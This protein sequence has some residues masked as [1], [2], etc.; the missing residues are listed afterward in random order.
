ME[1]HL[2]L[3]LLGGLFLLSMLVSH[4]AHRLNIPRVTLLIVSGI[5]IGPSGLNLVNGLEQL[6]FPTISNITLLV[7]GY[8]LGTKMTKIYVKK[9]GIAVLI[10]ALVI[11]AMTFLVVLLGLI[12]LN[13]PPVLAAILAVIAVAT[14]PT[15]TL[16][17]I[18]QNTLKNN[19]QFKA[20]LRGV[21]ALD[22]ILGL[23]LFSIVIAILISL[24]A[25]NASILDI[26]KHFLNETLGAIILGA[27]VGA[28][29][30]FLLNRKRHNRPVFV[31][32][33]GLILL[34]GGIASYLSM[35]YLLASMAM[36][37]VV[38]NYAHK[39]RSHLHDIELVEQ[40]FLILFFILAGASLDLSGVSEVIYLLSAYCLFRLLGRF[41]S[42]YCIPK[43]YIGI[44]KRQHLGLAFTSQAGVA[45]GMALVAGNQ[46]PLY[47][48]EILT[49][50]IAAT[51]LF[52]LTGPLL[53]NWSLNKNNTEAK[54]K[55]E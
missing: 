11:T 21:V 18:E 14:D 2:F 10:V 40:P 35:S 23:L 28:S 12:A 27:I 19:S 20:L 4:L 45:M 26:F 1:P 13:T 36:G 42:G 50:A 49:V 6:W 55:E 39:T 3:I 41:I 46:F 24:N 52:E 30:T 22:D 37:A 38:I 5:I 17:V 9:H 16:D 32:S 15:A 7:I 25:Q 53:T 29:L 44:V 33:F 31:E 48:N 43:Q 51:V 8:L 47:K 54:N 34:C